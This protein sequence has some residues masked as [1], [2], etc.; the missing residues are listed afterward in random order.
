M[1]AL[2][3]RGIK[4]EFVV[5]DPPSFEPAALETWMRTLVSRLVAEGF[6]GV[7]FG[8]VPE[9]VLLGRYDCL[10]WAITR[11]AAALGY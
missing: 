11:G 9:W 3:G 2:T 7:H 5:S 1:A 6:D 10:A 4:L 8:N